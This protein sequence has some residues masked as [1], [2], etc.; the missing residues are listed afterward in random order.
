MNIILINTIRSFFFVFSTLK[1]SGA[2][3]FTKDLK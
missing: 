3:L 2:V 1:K